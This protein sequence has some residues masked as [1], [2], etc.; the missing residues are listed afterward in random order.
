MGRFRLIYEMTF[1]LSSSH[2]LFPSLLPRPVDALWHRVD[3]PKDEDAELSR[4]EQEHEN[5]IKNIAEK[6]YPPPIG[7]T[8]QDALEEGEMDEDD[9]DEMDMNFGQESP[10]IPT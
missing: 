8:S 7:K 9:D 6:T 1:N 2:P 4:L 10:A 3:E 5:S